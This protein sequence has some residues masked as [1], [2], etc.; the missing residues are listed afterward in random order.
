[1]QAEY[2]FYLKIDRSEGLAQLVSHR[3]QQQLNDP[4]VFLPQLNQRLEAM[5]GDGWLFDLNAVTR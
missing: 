3:I 1:M 2:T 4:N 5:I